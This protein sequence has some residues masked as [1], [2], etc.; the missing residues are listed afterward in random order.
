MDFC[1]PGV[2]DGQFTCP[3][4]PGFDLL[5]FLYSLYLYLLLLLFNACNNADKQL[6]NKWDLVS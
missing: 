5:L 4:C 1:H 2:S 3:V 6:K